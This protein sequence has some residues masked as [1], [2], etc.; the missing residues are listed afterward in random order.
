MANIYVYEKDDDSNDYGSMGLAGGPLCPMECTFSETKNGESILSFT[1]PLDDLGRY[2][3]LQDNR[4]ILAPVPVY[5]Y[6]GVK[7]DNEEYNG[8]NPESKMAQVKGGCSYEIV[9]T[10]SK[11]TYL[12]EEIYGGV[13]L[14]PSST[15]TTATFT[16]DF[17]GKMRVYTDSPE[18]LS[19]MVIYKSS[20]RKQTNLY[21]S[22]SQ[23][24]PV[25]GGAKYTIKAYDVVG[26][27]ITRIRLLLDSETIKVTDNLYRPSRDGFL[28]FTTKEPETIQVNMISFPL[29][30]NGINV[31]ESWLYK[32]N[33]AV[34]DKQRWVYKKKKGTTK[35]NKA[36]IIP[37]IDK[38]TG[39]PPLVHVTSILNPD[40]YKSG[41]CEHPYKVKY[42]KL[43]GYMDA[44]AFDPV[45]PV[46]TYASGSDARELTDEE[47]RWQ[48]KN[49]LFRIYEIDKGLDSIKVSARH[50]TYDLLYNMTTYEKEGEVALL[51]SARGVMRDT[52]TPHPF[53]I[54]TDVMDM[55]AG[56]QFAGNNPIS[57]LLDE[58]SGLCSLYDVDVIRDNH[59]IVLMRKAGQARGVTVAYGKNLTGVSYKISTDSVLTRIVPIGAK[60]NGKPLYLNTDNIYKNA[61]TK[62]YGTATLAAYRSYNITWDEGTVT[63]LYF[64]PT[65]P[66][67]EGYWLVHEDPSQIFRPL[68]DPW[69]PIDRNG[70]PCTGKLTFNKDLS[71]AKANW[72]KNVKVNGTRYVDSPTRFGNYPIAY[73]YNLDCSSYK[74][75]EKQD[76]VTITTEK[77]RTYMLN[78][79]IQMFTAQDS[80]ID[81]P[82][83]EVSVEFVNLGD[84]EEYA[85]YK[86]LEN[87]FLF[88]YVNLIFPKQGLSN[89]LQI[90]K[91]E[92][93]VL[94]ER[95][96]SVELGNP[97]TTLAGCISRSNKRLPDTYGYS[98]VG[99]K[100][101]CNVTKHAAGMAF[102]VTKSS[103]YK[104][105]V[106][107]GSVVNGKFYKDSDPDNPI[108]YHL[109]SSGSYFRF[110]ASGTAPDF[111]TFIFD[112]TTNNPVA[113]DMNDSEME[114]LQYLAYDGGGSIE[115]K[116]TGSYTGAIKPVAID[117]DDLD[118]HGDT[119][120]YDYDS[121][122]QV[123]SIDISQD[124]DE[125][126]K[127]I[128]IP[129]SI[130]NDGEVYR[131]LFYVDLYY[132]VTELGAEVYTV[133]IET[134][135]TVQID[136][137]GEQANHTTLKA[138]VRAPD[139]TALTEDE[140]KNIGRLS[141]YKDKEYVGSG[142]EYSFVMPLS[143]PSATYVVRFE[144]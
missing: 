86:N 48:V 128:E 102:K 31:A 93:D 125:S 78:S 59:S 62:V 18:S 110:P 23:F 13:I 138:I 11:I 101:F 119:V 109:T 97:S 113:V 44:D 107:S 81:K 134:N 29:V 12:S 72:P 67:G 2:K 82:Q 65:I 100:N 6:G 56:L 55:R 120:D 66:A 57:A 92:W 115:I 47:S 5:N 38:K 116:F 130:L 142:M 87:C 37:A 114:E 74:V 21:D 88:D 1:H 33:S 30:Q 132:V 24:I 91:M 137:N 61:T 144:E 122:I 139:G 126:V 80:S 135:S 133:E 17:D 27:Y 141:W 117:I 77:A 3:E 41:E 99:S 26:Q 118:T 75:G 34:I 14:F 19:S 76:D 63:R 22:V 49:Q 25:K 15:G 85:D 71:K 112:V 95:M 73:T 69:S 51:A 94:L 68:T 140:I 42:G 52:I 104:I 108:D 8:F 131:G 28:I 36:G 4:I 127:Q 60:S 53:R 105:F 121:S 20:D 129:F 54:Y 70:N 106:D 89:S 96:I 84:T 39:Q 83:T 79:A 40:H 103:A 50:I 123:L 45:N 7:E 46:K 16:A 10:Y 9:G 90:V 58:S 143:E 124:I 43:S 98:I 32:I 64:E 111:G 136:D 35:S